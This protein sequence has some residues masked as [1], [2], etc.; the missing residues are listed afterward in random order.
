MPSYSMIPD[1]SPDL[2]TQRRASIRFVRTH[3]FLF[4]SLFPFRFDVH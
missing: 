4:L 2:L 3:A 1:A